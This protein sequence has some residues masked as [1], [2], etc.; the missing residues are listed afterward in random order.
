MEKPEHARLLAEEKYMSGWRPKN[1]LSGGNTKLA[2]S[3]RT[4]GLSL[5]P[6]NTS[7]FE[8]CASRTPECTKHRI[9]TYD[10]LHL[11]VAIYR[12]D[13][14]ICIGENGASE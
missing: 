5:A 13:P 7:G 14:R 1:L 3:A 10:M 4:L 6:A 9:S 8:F 12:D 11:F 2:K